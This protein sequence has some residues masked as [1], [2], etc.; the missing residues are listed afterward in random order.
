MNICMYCIYT[1]RV[2][3]YCLH[4]YMYRKYFLEL[5]ETYICAYVSYAYIH[6]HVHKI[7]SGTQRFIFLAPPPW[8]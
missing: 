3:T 8:V 4:T 5:E 1:Y 2:Y 6:I 7:E